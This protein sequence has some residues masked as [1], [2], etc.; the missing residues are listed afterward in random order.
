[1]FLALQSLK[2]PSLREVYPV[3]ER[4]LVFG[5]EPQAREGVD[6]WMAR[7]QDRHLSRHHA[8]AERIGNSLRLK[9]E[10]PPNDK[11]GRSWPNPFRSNDAEERELSEPVTLEPGQSIRIGSIERGS[12]TAVYWLEKPDAVPQPAAAKAGAEGSTRFP[13]IWKGMPESAKLYLQT[14]QDQLPASLASWSTPQELFDTGAHLVRSLAQG[15]GLPYSHAA[16]VSVAEGPVESSGS[17]CA[18]FLNEER[19]FSASF[20][21]HDRFLQSMRAVRGSEPL[22]WALPD[23]ADLLP[24]GEKKERTPAGLMGV[25]LGTQP[26]STE[27]GRKLDWK[28]FQLEGR[29][30]LLYIDF[31]EGDREKMEMVA[32]LARLLAFLIP[33]L[34]EARENQ[35]LLGQLEAY[36][37][38]K[39]RKTIREDPKTLDPALFQC[40]VLF[41]DRRGSSVAVEDADSDEKIRQKLFENRDILERITEIVL[42]EEGAIADFAGD[43]VLGFWGWPAEK[44]D[45]DHAWRAVRA[46][47]AIVSELKSELEFDEDRNV[48]L[49]KVRIGISTGKMAVGNVGPRQQMKIGVFGNPVNFGAR[50]EGLGKQFRVPILISEHTASLV[51]GREGIRLRKLAFMKPVGFE[52]A[53]PI[54]ELVVPQDCGGSGADAGRVEAYES[55]LELFLQRKWKECR[56]ALKSADDDDEPAHWLIK[57][58]YYYG[59]N[60]MHIPP[61]WQ[62]EIASLEK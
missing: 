44:G 34:L 38:P 13:A 41:C 19:G 24:R 32:P 35:R 56:N 39:L 4:P 10:T 26:L 12:D 60:P 49:P 54:F 40:T 15:C 33:R 8:V 23:E 1:M 50:L 45:S 20:A 37:S 36:F 55:A 9:R 18:T 14:L 27:S 47:L 5:R 57:Q 43:C 52:Q 28:P 11:Q 51:R 30:V 22:L 59:D 48:R 25:W 53:Y 2:D 62:G 61:N 3:G 29:R 21:I 17:G 46:G 7:W 42:R 16:F 31:S 58:A 6:V